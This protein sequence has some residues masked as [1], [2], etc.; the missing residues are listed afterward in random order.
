M[1]HGAGYRSVPGDSGD[2]EPSSGNAGGVL[3]DRVQA[4]RWYKASM[5]AWPVWDGFLDMLTHI[6][7]G[8]GEAKRSY[9]ASEPLSFSLATGHSVLLPLQHPNLVSN[10]HSFPRTS[11]ARSEARSP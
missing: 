2:Q 1:R 4:E 11:Q 9:K 8:S 6:R 10:N 5:L 7:L 3:D